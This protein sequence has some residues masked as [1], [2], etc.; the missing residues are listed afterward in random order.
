M[1]AFR[2]NNDH[3]RGT[4]NLQFSKVPGYSQ[5]MKI[6]Q[7]SKRDRG[8]CADIGP[9]CESPPPL[10][11]VTS[12]GVYCTA[13]LKEPMKRHLAAIFPA[14]SALMFV[15]C[16]IFAPRAD[17]VEYG[18]FDRAL[19][20]VTPSPALQGRF[21]RD[22][23]GVPATIAKDTLVLKGFITRN[24]E[25]LDSVM[26]P[27][28]Q[29]R[30]ADLKRMPQDEMISDLALF[31]HEM[32]RS[33]F[34]PGFYRWGGDILDLD[35]PQEEGNRARSLFGLDCSGFA[36]APYEIAVYT[37]LLVPGDSAAL[38]S[39]AGFAL[40]ARA[41]GMEDLGGRRKTS[42]RFRVDTHDLLRLGREVLRVPK[43]GSPDN[44]QLALLRSGD[45]VGRTGHVGI[46][47]LIEGEPYYLESGG[48]V[49]PRNGNYPHK[50]GPALA[51]FARGGELTVRRALP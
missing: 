36:S 4:C 27:A 7:Y 6:G 3:E 14:A 22:L 11:P 47:V 38:F 21:N 24:R 9:A 20:V 16:S 46:I 50:A 42:N 48:S 30:L 26:L 17:F 25:F 40:Y 8:R 12:P 18:T 23:P 32:Y 34:G 41:H 51:I 45:V 49:L 28:L 5:V 15:S 29:P 35:D 31:T 39:S 2:P 37:G 10:D 43:G 44:A 1:D 19:Q 13:H 33:W